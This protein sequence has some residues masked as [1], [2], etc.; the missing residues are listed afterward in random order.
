M[1]RTLATTIVVLA[2]CCGPAQRAAAQGHRPPLR[3]PQPP[4]TQTNPTFAPAAGDRAFMTIGGALC[5]S[6]VNFTSAIQPIDFAERAAIET[7]YKNRTLPGFEIG[8]GAR[9]WRQLAAAVTVERLWKAGSGQISAQVPHP[10]F[11]NRPRAVAGDASSL[12]HAE[13]AVHMQAVWTIPVTPRIELGVGGGPSW[14]NVTQAV[15]NDITVAQ[16]YPYDTA[17]FG[18]A[19]APRQTEGRIG[20]NA[21]MTLDYRFARRVSVAMTARFSHAHVRFEA[22]QAGSVDVDAGGTHVGGGI[23]FRF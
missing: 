11:F 19:V 9:V 8:G 5:V 2:A 1:I 14:I 12:D 3:P 7:R 10:F 18:S 22:A 16:T 15:V 23:R 21:G 4:P 13:T 6:S 17:S 20:V